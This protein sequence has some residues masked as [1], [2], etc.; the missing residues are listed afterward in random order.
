MCEQRRIT[1]VI[2]VNSHH[3]PSDGQADALRIGIAPVIFILKNV[4]PYSVFLNDSTLVPL[5]LGV[6]QDKPPTAFPSSVS[7]KTVAKHC[8]QS[9]KEELVGD[10]SV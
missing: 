4:C 1:N 8:H 9:P 2:L 3:P 5:S 10:T 6:R 7:K